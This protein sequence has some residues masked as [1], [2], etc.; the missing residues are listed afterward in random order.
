[1]SLVEDWREKHPRSSSKGRLA[2]YVFLLAVVILFIV[3]ANSIVSGFTS[4]F[5]PADTPAEEVDQR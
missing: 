3:K 5:F 2:V 1:M 4:I